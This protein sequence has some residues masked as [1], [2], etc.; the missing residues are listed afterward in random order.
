MGLSSMAHSYSPSRTY[1]KTGPGWRCGLPAWP[2]PS[3]T[4]T[5]VAFASL[6]TSFSL[7][8]RAE[9]TF[10]ASAFS[11]SWASATPPTPA[12]TASASRIRTIILCSSKLGASCSHKSR[13]ERLL[14]VHHTRCRV[15]H[16]RARS[17]AE[18]PCKEPSRWVRKLK[19]F[20]CETGSF[21]ARKHRLSRATKLDNELPH[22]KIRVHKQPDVTQRSD[23][24]VPV[25]IIV[26]RYGNPG[27][28]AARPVIG[29]TAPALLAV[30]RAGVKARMDDR[31]I[32]Q[33]ADSHV[34]GHKPADR[35]RLRR[36]LEKLGLV[37][38]RAVRIRD[39]EVV[40][41]NLLETLHIPP[42]H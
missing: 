41:Q 10:T 27:A 7:T 5:T 35:H 2:G 22:S 38:Q 40:G 4:S 24:S 3:V 36:Q 25:E 12:P 33:Q 11:R 15:S 19:R 32:T 37:E 30:G 1:P 42:L 31:E 20:R 29:V 34:L 28:V 17:A 6:P 23:L 9:R 21:V 8:S 14:Y 16:G 13:N 39:H 18:R 26:C